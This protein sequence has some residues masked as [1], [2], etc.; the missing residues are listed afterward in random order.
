MGNEKI[1]KTDKDFRKK[2]LLITLLLVMAGIIFIFYFQ[3]YLTGLRS[4]AE[5]Y[6]EL[7]LQRI[8]NSMII[9]I[10]SLMIIFA[11]A[12]IY[13]LR[14]GILT[15]KTSQFPPP[16]IKVIKDTRLIEGKNAVRKG[17]IIIILSMLFIISGILLPIQYYNIMHT[18]LM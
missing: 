16:G 3:N 7:A 5:E 8:I 14:L 1:V 15:I 17:I 10:F 4:L 13:F 11:G 6:P 12:G 18:I 2:V 9:I